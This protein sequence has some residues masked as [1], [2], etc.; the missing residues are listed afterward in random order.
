MPR[1]AEREVVPGTVSRARAPALGEGR[2]QHRPIIHGDH[3]S[4]L[5]WLPSDCRNR[6]LT[7]A[8]VGQHGNFAVPREQ[9]EIGRRALMPPGS[10]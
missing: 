7:M 10:L 2:F 3:G 4:E 1:T 5:H 9:P 8:T 6:L